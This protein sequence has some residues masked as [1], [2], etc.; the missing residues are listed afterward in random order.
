MIGLQAVTAVG[1]VLLGAAGLFKLV[2]PSE[3]SPALKAV[4]LPS[5]LAIIRALGAG[6]IALGLAVI[7]SPSPLLLGLMAGT[8]LAFAGFSLVALRSGA[9][10]R[11][12]GCFGKIDTPPS[13]IHVGINVLI[14]GAAGLVAAEAGALTDLVSGGVAAWVGVLLLAYLVFGT[15]TALPVAVAARRPA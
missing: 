8:Y 14:A 1:A 2:R 15:L 12:C 3:T 9:P 7:A 10:L 11:S 4:G 5:S 6:E 13:S